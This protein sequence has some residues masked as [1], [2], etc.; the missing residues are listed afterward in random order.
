VVATAPAGWDLAGQ[1][2][3]VRLTALLDDGVTGELLAR[4]G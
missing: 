3:P 4:E 1:V 2:T